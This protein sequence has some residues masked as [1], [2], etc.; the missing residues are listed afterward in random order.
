MVLKTVIVP[1][2]PHVVPHV[3]HRS[4]L[5]TNPDEDDSCA[6]D[7]QRINLLASNP[8]STSS[9]YNNYHSSGPFQH[10]RLYR[11]IS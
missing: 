5:L 3:S 7:V 1:F 6:A 9:K 8:L 11:K 4:P 2:E 10:A